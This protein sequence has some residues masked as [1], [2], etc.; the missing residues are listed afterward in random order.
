MRKLKNNE[1][2]RLSVEEFKNSDKTPIIIILDNIRS[3]NN[4][5]CDIF[6]AEETWIGR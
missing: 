5:G 6:M 2:D 3:L 1:L 4:I